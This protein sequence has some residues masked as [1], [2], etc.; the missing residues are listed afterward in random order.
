MNQEPKR[1]ALLICLRACLQEHCLSPVFE[2]GCQEVC[3][4]ADVA[5]KQRLWCIGRNLSATV[6][7]CAQG[8][9]QDEQQRRRV[10]EQSTGEVSTWAEQ[11]L[12]VVVLV[13]W[14]GTFKY[15]SGMCIVCLLQQVLH[16]VLSANT[17]AEQL[18]A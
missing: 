4:D 18:L 7:K 15:V 6:Q 10:A 17:Y 14:L 5:S 11:L 1:K 13:M 2:L 12:L 16:A 8:M 3:N 9:Q